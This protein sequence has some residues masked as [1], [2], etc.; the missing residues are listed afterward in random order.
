MV[1]PSPLPAGDAAPR[2]RRA[3]LS[4]HDK[5]GLVPFAQALAARGVTLLSTGGTARTLREAGL[6]VVDVSEVTGFPE[7]MDGRV[8]TLHPRVHGGLLALRDVDAHVAAMAQHGIEPIDLLVVSL[9]PFEATVARPGVTRAEAIEQ[10]DI[11]GPAMIRSAAKNHR[12]VGVVTDP[13]QYAAVQADL[14]VHEGRLSASLREALAIAAYARTSAYDAAI[15]AWLA[16]QAGEVLPPTLGTARKA[17]VLRYGENPHQ[18]GALYVDPA[19]PPGSLVRA[20]VL[21]GKELSFN[22]YGDAEAAWALVRELAQPACVVVKHANPCGVAMRPALAA[23]YEAAVACDPRS[24]FGGVLALNRPLDVA[25]ARAM[26]VPE[27]FFEVLV[28][29]GVEPGAEEVFLAAS[30]PRWGRSLRILDAG[31]TWSAPA[32]LDVRGLDGGLLAQERDGGLYE[33]GHPRVVTR[34]APS[35]REAADLAFACAVVKHVRS[36]AIVLARDLTA[37]G[38]GAGQMSR[39]EATEIAATRARR[40]AA[41]TGGSLAGAVVASDAFYPFNDGIEAALALG[42][43]AL[44]QPGGSRNDEAAVALCDARQAAMLFTGRRHFRH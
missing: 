40:W 6:A 32:G 23:A 9:Y 37:V 5:Q 8:K 1:G 33:P 11:G 41:E 2:V 43:T 30:A 36:N 26:A 14:E 29:P 20:R 12:S 15:S 25:L 13:S 42:V 16:R 31:R 27:R 38:V 39:V 17:Q 35:E 7:M 4:V 18:Q 3:L 10:V 19:A 28:C 22:N 21:G 34:R 24:A 44:A